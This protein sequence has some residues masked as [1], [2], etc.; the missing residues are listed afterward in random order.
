M[1]LRLPSLDADDAGASAFALGVVPHVPAP[2]RSR[3]PPPLM[4]SEQA[5]RAGG[6]PMGL[7]SP[8]SSAGLRSPP[9]GTASAVTATGTGG[10]GGAAPIP[11]ATSSQHHSMGLT[12][13]PAPPA[14]GCGASEP[15]SA[16]WTNTQGASNTAWDPTWSMAQIRREETRR[17]VWAAV[18]VVGAFCARCTARNEEGLDLNI[19]EAGNVCHFLSHTP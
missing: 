6:V 4:L 5:I 17:L 12:S 11:I 10:V 7:P 19:L 8:A 1:A 16:G 9:A 14:C 2:A 15:V 13:S 3:P 18:S